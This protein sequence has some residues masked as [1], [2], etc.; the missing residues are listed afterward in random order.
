MHVGACGDVSRRCYC[1]KLCCLLHITTTHDPRTHANTHLFCRVLWWLHKHFNLTLLSQ[2][3]VSESRPP[4]GA[5]LHVPLHSLFHA[6][7]S[8][9]FA[10][11]IHDSR[12]RFPLS[13][14]T[15]NIAS[16]VFV[17]LREHRPGTITRR[18]ACGKPGRKPFLVCV[19]NPCLLACKLFCTSLQA[20]C[21][22]A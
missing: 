13:A 11:G 12:R 22:V 20:C 9:I 10:L 19:L 16:Y 14:P 8:A 1:V 17:V 21:R 3:S 6:W 7:A 4:Q 18:W 5:L 15:L 2:P